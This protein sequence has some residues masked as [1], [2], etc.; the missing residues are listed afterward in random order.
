MGFS[1]NT[2]LLKFKAHICPKIVKKAHD[3]NSVDFMIPEAPISANNSSHME[4]GLVEISPR[5]YFLEHFV[6]FF[7]N[8]IFEIFGLFIQK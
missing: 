6:G 3:A 7:E 2:Y 5:T 4:L 8:A 1:E